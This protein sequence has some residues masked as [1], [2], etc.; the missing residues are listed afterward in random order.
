M[1][2]KKN[3]GYGGKRDGAGRPKKADELTLIK[4]IDKYADT[5]NLI[6]RIVKIM[7]AKDSRASD[8]L[9]AITLLLEYKYGK[10]TQKFDASIESDQ[11]M[12]ILNLGD[13]V[14]IDL[15]EIRNIVKEVNE[16]Y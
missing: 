12:N 2:F 1:G 8:K 5:D 9:K 14:P 11:P 13:G 6:K 7:D 16:E 3:N 4:A 10:P 15:E